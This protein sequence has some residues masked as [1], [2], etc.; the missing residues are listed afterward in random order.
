MLAALLLFFVGI[1]VTDP[2]VI[3][4]CG[5]CHKV[6]EQGNMQRVSFARATPEGWQSLLKRKLRSGQITIT[7][8]EAR[9]ILTYLSD[10]HGLAPEESQP[11]MYEPER[12]VHD[13]TG[14]A[15]ET[16]LKTCAKCH[17]LA[18][19]L[20]WRRTPDDWKQFLATHY[21]VKV[22]DDLINLISEAAPLDTPQWS[23][24]ASRKK[25]ADLTG[26]WLLTA[27]MQGRGQFC[28]ELLVKAG[29]SPGEFLTLVNL[30]SIND[31]YTI[32]R[33]GRIAVYAGHEWRGHSKGANMA[34]SSPDDPDSDARE[35]MWISP[36][37]SRM[38]GRWFWGQ[39]QEF[40]FDVT[41]QRASGSTLLALNVASFKIGS[42]NNRVRLIGDHFPAKVTSADI[43]AGAG[44]TVR[45][46]ISN[47]PSEIVAELDVSSSAQPGRRDITLAN[48]TLP[49]AIAIYDRIDY[50]RVMPDS[51]MAAFGNDT[52]IRGFQQFEAIAYQR[53][54]D[55]RL[56]TADDLE[57]G[58]IKAVWSMEVFY[59][60]DTSQHD[61]VGSISQ[62]GFFTPAAKNA[63]TNY[64]I[65][66][67]ATANGMTGKSYVVV[68]IPTYQFQGRTYVRDLDRWIAEEQ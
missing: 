57:L 41:A 39:Y 58:P 19:A 65:W 22:S 46:I 10:T 20:S 34:G 53:G 13:E 18:K 44:V 12:R 15:N 43:T 55:N 64:D 9:A 6:D 48:S 27:H 35:A 37:G 36:D 42:Q 11:L 45:R 67:I 56:H 60:T 31:G 8:P 62:T 5:T 49:A 66:V 1:P 38:Q 24:W 26:R 25:S 33:S 14:S 17:T 21:K 23:S 4:K 50:I 59:E 30:R 29:T 28:G 63:G 61:I 47:S 51:A 40:G 3:A 16:L 7:Q 52:H 2:T 54:P 68:T 32:E